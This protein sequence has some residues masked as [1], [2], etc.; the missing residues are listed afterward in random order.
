MDEVPLVFVESVIRSSDLY[1]SKQLEQLSSAWG[2]VGEVQTKKSGHLQ[3]TF[4]A[5]DYDYEWRI[6][7]MFYGFNHIK[8][9]SLSPEVSLVSIDFNLLNYNLG[10]DEQWHSISPDDIALLQLLTNL[11][12]PKKNLD[13]A[14]YNIKESRY[15]EL[16]SKYSNLLRSFTSVKLD[17]FHKI[18]LSLLTEDTISWSKLRTVEITNYRPTSFWVYFFFSE[19]CSRLKLNDF[20]VALEVID[21]WKK[22]DPRTLTYSKLLCGI[23]CC[24]SALDGVGMQLVDRKSGAPLFEKMR[25]K[26]HRHR[27]LTQDTISWSKLRTVEIINYRP[28]SFWVDFFFSGRCSRLKLN[29]FF[30]ALEVIDLWKMMDPRTLTY[31]KL[32]CVIS[33][34]LSAFDGVGM[35]LVDR[36]SGAPLFEKMRRKVDRHRYIT[37]LYRIDHPTDPRSKIYV[38]FY[39]DID[40]CGIHYAAFG[41]VVILLD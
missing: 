10:N 26:V 41:E 36:K 34:S 18:Q 16:R 25:R 9:R 24:L 29:D 15:V 39:D 40:M 37:S 23:S 28:T 19:R 4:A 11:D 32:F 22:M 31:S 35:Q 33:C 6:Y 14:S 13:L 21:H 2:V 38:V 27:L 12:A 7:Y 17:C 30:V 20:S 8:S 1:A 3:L 5:H